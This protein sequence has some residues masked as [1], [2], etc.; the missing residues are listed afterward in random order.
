MSATADDAQLALGRK[1]F[2]ELSEPKCAVCHTLADAASSG[3]VGPNLDTLKPDVDRVMAAITQGIG[4][5]PANEV[6]SEEQIKAVA[7]YVSSIAGKA[8]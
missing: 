5:M 6:L 4:A 2:T 3:E 7:R 1:V 8:N